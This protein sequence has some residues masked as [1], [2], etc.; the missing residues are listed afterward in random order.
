M[1]NSFDTPQLDETQPIKHQILTIRPPIAKSQFN[2][3]Y[4]PIGESDDNHE[5]AQGVESDR[6]TTRSAVRLHART[7]RPDL[8]RI[9]LR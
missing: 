9:G 5:K 7:C 4:F 1:R 2:I 6:Q 8:R 3:G